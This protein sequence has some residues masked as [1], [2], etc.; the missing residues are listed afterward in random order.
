MESANQVQ[1]LAEAACVYLVLMSLGKVAPY[2][3]TV[4]YN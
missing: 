4:S 3:C 1:N 2:P